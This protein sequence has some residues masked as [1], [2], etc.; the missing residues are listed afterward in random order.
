MK[1]E[2]FGGKQVW[3]CIWDMQHGR[4]GRVPSRVITIHDE[5]DILCVSTVSQHQ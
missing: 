1:Q 5:D 2:T 3:N 4:R